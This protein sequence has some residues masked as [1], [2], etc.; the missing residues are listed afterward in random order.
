MHGTADTVLSF[1]HG[2]KLYAAAPGEKMNLW[3]EGA[4]HNDYAYVAGNDY[5]D[6]F[7]T[8]MDMVRNHKD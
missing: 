4:E 3:I 6:S 8:F 7:Q 1:W 2:K 5:M